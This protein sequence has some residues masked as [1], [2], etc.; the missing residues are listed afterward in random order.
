M[1]KLISE[2]ELAEQI[3]VAAKTLERWRAQGFGPRFIKLARH[4]RY[5]SR[6]V[7]AW[8]DG[9]RRNSTSQAA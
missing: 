4:V 7:E 1:T 8:L 5:D 3:G 2:R 6:D 9:Q